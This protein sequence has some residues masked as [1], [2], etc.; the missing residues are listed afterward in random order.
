MKLYG[1][2]LSIVLSLQSCLSIK[3]PSLHSGYNKLSFSQKEQIVFVPAGQMIPDTNK[4]IIYAVT[5]QSVL[6]SI[7]HIDSTVVYNWSPRCRGENCV[8]LISAQQACNK[9][10]YNLFV[11]AAY[12]DMEEFNRQK[13]LLTNPL[14]TVH[15]E[16]YETDFYRK[17]IRLFN[18]DL[19]RGLVLPDSVKYARYYLFHKNKFVAAM[20]NIQ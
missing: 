7:Q 14:L 2:V 19:L 1:V 12:Y 16:Y 5:A 8:S 9:K 18:D 3:A 15:H 11:V 20:N 17:N 4:H 10:G 6:N 13:T